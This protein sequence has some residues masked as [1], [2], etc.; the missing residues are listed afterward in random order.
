M[1]DQ[2]QTSIAAGA[3]NDNVLTGSALEFLD[4]H[5]ALDFGLVGSATGLLIDVYVGNAIVAE[6]MAPSQQNRVPVWPEDFTLRTVGAA[7]ER[8]KIR[9]RNTTGGALT[10]FHTVNQTPL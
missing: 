7:G 8:L 10:L 5:S 6:N 1:L 2:K 4:R 9:V 3:T